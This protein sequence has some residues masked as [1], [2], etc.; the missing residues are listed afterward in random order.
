MDHPQAD[1]EGGLRDRGTNASRPTHM[2]TF[3][4]VY[5]HSLLR[6]HTH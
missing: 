2:H 6:T 3:P 1:G 4:D 5:K